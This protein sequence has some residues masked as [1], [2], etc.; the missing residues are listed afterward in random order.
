MCSQ[1]KEFH[2]ISFL[3]LGTSASPQKHRKAAS[4][5]CGASTQSSPSVASTLG[6]HFATQNVF[7]L[8]IRAEMSKNVNIEVEQRANCGKLMQTAVDCES[9]FRGNDS[10]PVAV[11]SPRVASSICR[12]RSW[13]YLKQCT[14][15]KSLELPWFAALQKKSKECRCSKQ[16]ASSSSCRRFSYADKTNL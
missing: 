1:N 8:L 10:I 2:R 13:R 6:I 15:G 7:W 3:M 12:R 4:M 5:P 16:R 9:T 11:R 14:A